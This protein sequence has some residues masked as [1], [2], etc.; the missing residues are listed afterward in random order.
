MALRVE[1][2]PVRPLLHE[3]VPYV[4]RLLWSAGLVRVSVGIDDAEDVIADF[5]QGLEG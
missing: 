5:R 2:S 3:T 1:K 4:E